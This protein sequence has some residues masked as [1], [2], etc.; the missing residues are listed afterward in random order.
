MTKYED[1]VKLRNDINNEMT[2]D[3]LSRKRASIL[4]IQLVK[5]NEMIDRIELRSRDNVI[6]R[7]V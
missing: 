5:V 7:G 4:Q 1:L 3:E 6:E 2:K